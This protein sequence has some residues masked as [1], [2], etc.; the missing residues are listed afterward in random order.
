MKKGAR[1]LI[2]MGILSTSIA[3]GST[4]ASLA[5]YHNSGDIYLDRSRPG[6]LPDE[7][8]IKSDE[9]ENAADYEFDEKNIITEDLLDEY[10]KELDEEIENLD[11]YAEPFGEQAL[12]NEKLGI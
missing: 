7:D 2:I 10:L 5:V 11:G 4:G 6:F 3:L 9:A 12:S 1:N 8:E